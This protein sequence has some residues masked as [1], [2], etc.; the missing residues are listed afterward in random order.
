MDN[1]GNNNLDPILNWI[2]NSDTTETNEK[3]VSNEL[4]GYLL[5]DQETSN[6]PFSPIL[7]KD[8]TQNEDSQHQLGKRKNENSSPSEEDDIDDP[9]EAQLQQL[10]AKERRKLRNKISARNFRN[11]RKEYMSTLEERMDKYQAENSQ[12]KLEVKW[13][14]GMMD[15]LQAENDQ[16]R[17]ELALC[18]GGIQQPT[19]MRI[20]S[21]SPPTSSS[22]PIDWEVICPSLVPTANTNATAVVTTTAVTTPNTLSSSSSAYPS[23]HS[24]TSTSNI[25]T[26]N[27]TIYLAHATVPN[28]DLSNLFC[29]EATSTVNLIHNYPLLAPALMSIV[30]QHTMTMTT[31]DIISNSKFKDPT[32]PTN[33][34]SS[35][36]QPRNEDKFIAALSDSALWQ[37]II[38]TKPNTTDEIQET[39]ATQTLS[40]IE[41]N[42]DEKSELT[43]MKAY[44][45]NYCPMKWMQKQFCMFI[46]FYVV[47]QYPRLDKPCRTYL[48]ICDKFRVKRQIASLK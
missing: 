13:I 20:A 7:P 5:N 29:K 2:L 14:K 27:P 10:P 48:P 37:T 40:F 1:N 8:N 23:T 47:V 17:L 38:N 31:E 18:K 19:N 33:A 12:L 39:K 28:W 36:Y 11:R 34:I 30:L 9:T 6:S 46:L 15:K 21:V 24:L 43:E 26:L 25:D 42:D 3:Q 32:I 41:N 16:L 22:N 35:N 45:K 44:M 4:L